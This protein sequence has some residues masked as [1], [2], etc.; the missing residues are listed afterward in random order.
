MRVR[1]FTALR[2]VVAAL[3]AGCHGGG[4]PAAPTPG[5]PL[6][7]TS[8]VPSR[9]STAGA[10]SV[11]ILGTGFEAGVAVSFSGTPGNVVVLSGTALR[12]TTPAH[13]AGEVAVVVTNPGGASA[14][15]AQPFTY[16]QDPPPPST[17]LTLTSLSP[18]AGSTDGGAEVLLSGS[19][20]A[21][22]ARVTFDGVPAP[23][24]YGSS[25][26]MIAH[27]PAHAAGSVD[28]VVTNPDGKTAR[29]P[30][31]YASPGSFEFNG[32]WDA[33]VSGDEIVFR[34][35]IRDNA[36]V[37]VTCRTSAS[38]ALTPAPVVADGG[39]SFSGADGAS[40]S[41]RLVAPSQAIGEI[42]VPVCGAISWF[43]SRRQ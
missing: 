14:T 5:T 4:Q 41:G 40:M 42:N 21:P 26:V 2:L 7:V 20:F 30:F 27:P 37:S 13:A 34:F 28:V 29:R 31:R 9:G 36:L 11:T 33:V 25:Q 38:I 15:L 16:V 1:R 35:T 39:F 32:D 10:T 22:G 17:S 18:D 8:I 43:A 19:N 12:A 23:L 6:A 24:A 3:G